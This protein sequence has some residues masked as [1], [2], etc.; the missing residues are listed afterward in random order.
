VAGFA[1]LL[2]AKIA[3]LRELA[4]F[5]LAGLPAAL[6]AARLF[7]PGLAVQ[8]GPTPLA[9]R[10][11]A[12]LEAVLARGRRRALVLAA[13]LV[14][15]VALAV[16]GMP[17]MTWSD[18]FGQLRRMDPALEREDERVRQEVARYE[19]RRVVLALGADEERALRVNDAAAAAL[20]GAAERGV[21]GGFRGIATLLP[22]AE[23]QAAVAAAVRSEPELWP[24]MRAALEAEGFDVAA[25]EPF[26]AALLERDAP[27]PL[28]FADLEASAL[29]PLVR[30]FRVHLGDQVGFVSFLHELRDE[31]ALR[32]SLAGIP[33]ARLIDVE[34]VLSGAYAR[35]R[36]DMLALLLAGWGAV[37]AIVAL[38]HRKLRPLLVACLPALLAT[39]GTIGIVSLLGMQLDLLCLMALLMVAS[40]G[41][42]YGVLLAEPRSSPPARQ[43]TL[44]A[45]F[46]AGTTT[47]L[48]LGLLASS[49][50]PALFE[51]G[52]TAGLGMLLCLVSA[53]SI[54]ALLLPREA[55]A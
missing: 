39:T 44:L 45:V 11:A 51:I 32:E 42:D 22:S 50:Q 34:A 25:F 43:A 9:R 40:M 18:G 46:L 5:A 10:L 3:G 6:L 36:S 48:G 55:A 2:L 8:A 7:L 54:A 27:G 33:G 17:R 23:R 21:L 4:L 20:E 30:P 13:P 26:R 14:V 12:S 24:R 35:Y 49:A 38:R 41:N 31:R 1:L 53:P 19:Q 37:V 16:A 47:L 15:I 29:A 52:V 28:R